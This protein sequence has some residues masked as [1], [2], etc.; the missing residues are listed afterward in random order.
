MGDHGLKG[1]GLFQWQPKAEDIG[2][3]YKYFYQWICRKDNGKPV[4]KFIA[5]ITSPTTASEIKE[6]IRETFER[7]DW[8]W[9]EYPEA[10][11]PNYSH[12]SGYYL[13]SVLYGPYKSPEEAEGKRTS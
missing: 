11:C 9:A 12:H 7:T 10:E 2:F 13:A 4:A 1:Y 3:S 8:P 6:E 5:G